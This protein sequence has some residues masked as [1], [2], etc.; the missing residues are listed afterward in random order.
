VAHHGHGLLLSHL[1][2]S[3]TPG[4]QH[5]SCGDWRGLFSKKGKVAVFSSIFLI[6]TNLG[7]VNT[8]GC[9][10]VTRDFWPGDASPNLSI[11]CTLRSLSLQ[12]EGSRRPSQPQ[13]RGDDDTDGVVRVGLEYGTGLSVNGRKGKKGGV[14]YFA[15]P[16]VALG[17]AR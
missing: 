10:L 2:V 11:C 14:R 15:L 5:A 16:W 1:G 9:V 6:H 8:V 12:G 13:A 3:L 7:K 17:Y 4:D